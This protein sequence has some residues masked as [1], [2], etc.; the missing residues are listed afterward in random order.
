MDHVIGI[1]TSTTATKAVLVDEA[2]S[3]VGIGVSEYG[4]ETPHPLWSE[5]EPTLWWEATVS[6]IREVL[7]ETAVSADTVVAVGLTG[8]MHGLVVLDERG[9]PIR[10]AILWNDQRTAAECDEI[11][12]EVGLGRLVAITGNDCLT[13]FTAPKLRWMR[14]HEPAA[15]DR[16]AQVLLPKDYVRYRLTGGY[17]TD[18]A[19]AAG[20]LLVDLDTRDWSPELLDAL[21]FDRSWFPRTHE[22]PEVTGEVSAAA[23]AVTGLVEGT[24]VVGGGGDQAA[25]AVGTGVV[26]PGV[27]MV[28]LGTS[29]VVFAASREPIRDPRGRVHAFCHAVPHRWHTMGVMLSA[30]GSLRWWRD[31]AAPRRDFASLVTEAAAAP[32]G[33]DGL[34]FLPYLTGER[35]PHADPLARGAFVG[36]SVRHGR[37]HL[38]RAVVEG[39][40]FGLK[41]GLDLMTAA[42]LA[43]VAEIRLTGGGARSA[44]WQQIV[45]DVLG[46]PVVTVTTTEGPAYGAALLAAV[47]ARWHD[48]VADAVAGWIETSPGAEPGSDAER[49]GELHRRFRGVYPA[50]RPTF[51]EAGR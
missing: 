2:G 10:P 21:G 46:A 23:A 36:L 48:D 35:T 43:D 51:D 30:A 17:A 41:D 24:P 25:G 8:Q 42:G 47:G 11:R 49:Y 6:A 31:V 38:T 44:L 14:N 37:A 33:S 12:H 4:F 22:G 15:F 3:V 39:V 7:A 27:L 29:G 18:R 5:Q 45:A 34:L 9:T 13:G 19:G 1:D 28:S 20:T 40:T 50:L 16:V 26:E 32:V